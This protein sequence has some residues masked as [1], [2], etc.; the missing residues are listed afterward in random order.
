MSL[1]AFHDVHFPLSIAFGAVGGPE[2][3]TQIVQMASGAEQRTAVWAGSRRRWDVG[4]AI[5]TLDELHGLVGFFEAR[6]GPLFGF[7]FRD[8]TDDRSCAPEQKT[9]PT[10]QALGV[11]DG[12][13][14]VFQLVKAYGDTER[15]ILKPVAESVR[16]AIDGVETLSGFSV[17][18]ASGRVHFDAPPIQGAALSAGFHFDCPARFESDRIEASLEGFGA[19][20]IAR[21]GLIELLG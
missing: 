14:T 21:I 20:R 8:V 1:N 2:R 9:S 17:D 7:R 13:E 19:G 4:S 12:F 6:R 5:T 18:T 11:G 10:D 15:Q 3:N 16:I